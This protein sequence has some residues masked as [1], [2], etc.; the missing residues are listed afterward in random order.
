[1]DHRT[2]IAC[3][4]LGAPLVGCDDDAQVHTGVGVSATSG[5]DAFEGEASGMA[6][7]VPPDQ[8]QVRTFPKAKGGQATGE[9]ADYRPSVDDARAVVTEKKATELPSGPSAWGAPDAESGAALPPRRPMNAAARKA[10]QQG[11]SAARS[12][13]DAT[14]KAAFERALAADPGAYQA[15]YDLGVLA[16]RQGATNQ[17]LAYYARALKIQPDY[18][19]AVKGTVTIHVRQG[20]PQAAV[21]H[22]QP[23]ASKWER[24]LHLQA[25]LAEALVEAGRIDE[26]ERAARKALRRDERFVPAMVALAK[27]SLRRGRIE[28][29][30]SILEQAAKIKPKNPEINFLQGKR[31]QDE[32]RLA[33]ALASYRKA[34]EQRPDY[35][36][37]RMALGIQYMAAGNYAQALQQFEIVVR[38]VPTQVAAHLNLG[39]AYRANRRWQDAKREFDKALRMQHD[40]PEAH[41]N[42]ALMYMSAGAEFPGLGKLDALERAMLEFNTYRSKMGP[43]LRRDDPST[44]YISDLSRQIG[45]EKKRIEREAARKKKEAERAARKAAMEAEQ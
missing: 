17:A 28:L 36:E 10:Y 37:A 30:D 8:R 21:A 44:T 34:V 39:D 3:L 13:K 15:A 45:R 11:I 35:A 25:I 43:R 32:G 16:D 42:L 19:R 9:A 1:M 40:L 22:A 33:K 4:L 20:S 24:N 5:G 29:A 7:P 23:I 6:R 31:H 26:A 38:L 18:E 14:A 27:A 41:F 2:V 12:G